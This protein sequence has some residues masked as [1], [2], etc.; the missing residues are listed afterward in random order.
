MHRAKHFPASLQLNVTMSLCSG[1]Q[2]EG[3]ANK[4]IP[5]ATLQGDLRRHKLKMREATRV[6]TEIDYSV[7]TW[8]KIAQLKI[9]ASNHTREK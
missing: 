8:K 5:H 3:P 9:H 6:G 2:N 4:N 7:S 1:K